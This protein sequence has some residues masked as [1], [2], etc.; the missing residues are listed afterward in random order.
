[1]TRRADGRIMYRYTEAG[2]RLT[3]YGSTADDCLA[4]RYAPR[5]EVRVDE[6]TT[7]AAFLELWLEGL[8]LRDNTI[9]AHQYNVRRWLVPL[10]GTRVRLAKVERELIRSKLAEL[11]TTP[12]RFGTPPAP[13]TVQHAFATLSAA[14]TAAVDDGRLE[15]N[16]CRGLKANTA[17]AEEARIGIEHPIPTELELR[18]VMHA[19]TDQRLRLLQVAASTGLRQSELLGLAVEDLDLVART[20]HVHR[21]LRRS[22]RKLGRVKNRASNRIVP[23]PAALVPVLRA[24]L[25]ELV[26]L[27]AIAGSSWSNPSGLL[28]TGSHGEPLVGS[29]VTHWFEDLTRAELGRSFRWHDLRHFYA[30]N[31]LARDVPIAKVAKWLG[32]SSTTITFTTYYHV[33]RDAAAADQVELA[34]GVLAAM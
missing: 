11:R 12:T 2:D 21:S 29:T 6:R 17:E 24:Q 9:E 18:R 33:I 34:G 31:L 16:P 19:A 27:E 15:S 13:N 5:P 4:K 32:H 25:D 22:D 30:S 1:M 28:W 26:I 14:M 23:V 7:L 3:V 20:I 8:T 10:F